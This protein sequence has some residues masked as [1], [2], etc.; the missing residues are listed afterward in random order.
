MKTSQAVHG[1]YRAETVRFDS[2]GVELV[3]RLYLPEELDEPAPAAPLLGP[4]CSVKEQSPIQY[5]T[6]LADEGLVALAFDARGHGE[7]GGTPRRLERPIDKVADMGAA[8]DFLVARPEVDASRIG[9]VG[10][11]YG[12]ALVL[13]VA[14]DDHRV[15]AV[16]TVSGNHRD[17]AN[18]IE[19]VGGEALLHGDITTADA[20]E[21]LAARMARAIAAKARY[22]QSGEVEYQPI[23]DPE[24]TDVALPWKMIWDWYHGWSD[25]GLWENRYAV[26]GDVEYLAF[27]SL[28]AAAEQTKPHLM[29]HGEFSDGPA[30]CRRHFDALAAQEKELIWEDGVTHF[31]YY[32]DPETID[33]AVRNVADWFRQH[34]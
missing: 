32:E 19:L 27:E 25:R 21:R 20:E 26:M 4:F 33:R 6:R 2:Q 7:S 12:A 8:I 31:Q 15:G 24:R 11:C 14:A 1:R 18:D 5:A 13:R 34:L 17:H 28:T 16:A 30:S 3:G 29:V 22:E 23:V 10:I 9:A